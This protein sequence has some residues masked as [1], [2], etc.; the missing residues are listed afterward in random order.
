M[1]IELF[2]C[3]FKD[4]FVMKNIETTKKALA[5]VLSFWKK[6]YKSSLLRA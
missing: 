5:R 4:Y 2:E 1:C 6:D 3:G